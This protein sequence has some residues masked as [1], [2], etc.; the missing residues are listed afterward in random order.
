M[1]DVEIGMDVKAK[2]YLHPIF[3]VDEEYAFYTESI[4]DIV[5]TIDGGMLI[6]KH[7]GSVF[8]VLVTENSEMIRKAMSAATE[9]KTAALKAIEDMLEE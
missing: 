3:D 4:E 6:Y 1:A 8:P 5:D 2:V 7:G 9:Y